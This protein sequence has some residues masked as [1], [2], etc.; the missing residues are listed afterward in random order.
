MKFLGKAYSKKSHQTFVRNDNG[1]EKFCNI[2]FKTLD[3]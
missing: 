1:F 3:K 2:T